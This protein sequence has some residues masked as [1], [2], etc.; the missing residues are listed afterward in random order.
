MDQIVV[1]PAQLRV[2]TEPFLVV[3]LAKTFSDSA[4]TSSIE[5]RRNKAKAALEAG[6]AG[7]KAGLTA[8]AR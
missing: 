1:T 5:A 2:E 8:A 7:P 6:G 3:P 4:R